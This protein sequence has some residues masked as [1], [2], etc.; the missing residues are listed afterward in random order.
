M[1][2]PRRVSS[3]LGMFLFSI[4][5]AS[6]GT[7]DSDIASESVCSDSDPT[8]NTTSGPVCGVLGQG[9][10]SRQGN[11]ETGLVL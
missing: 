8:V 5:A 9:G 7:S 10:V 4:T 3:V 1:K 11:K 2:M 6:C